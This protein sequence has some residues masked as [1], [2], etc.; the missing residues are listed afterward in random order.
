MKCYY[1]HETEAVAIC[2]SC[3]RALCENCAADIHPGTACINRCEKDVKAL[4]VII[5]RNKSVYQKTGK[6]HK[7]NAIA[8]LMSGLVFLLIGVIPIIISGNY[9]S[10]FIAI[11]GLIFLL[12][13]FFSY[14]SGKQIEAPEEMPDR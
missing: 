2:K 7:R 1:H 10:S 12:W 6:A 5:E 3:N 4:N 9:S 14:R 8:M 13:S 11:L